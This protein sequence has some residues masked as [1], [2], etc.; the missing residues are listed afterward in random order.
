MQLNMN[1]GTQR[2]LGP[3]SLHTEPMPR[4]KSTKMPEEP[5]DYGPEDDVGQPSIDANAPS[6]LVGI[7][8][9]NA[10]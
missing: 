3:K 5:L 9:R 7:L 1:R 6:D 10:F 2:F 8:G 4:M